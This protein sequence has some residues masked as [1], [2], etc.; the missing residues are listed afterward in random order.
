VISLI[1][2]AS[3]FTIILLFVVFFPNLSF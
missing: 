1:Q 2:N 3:I